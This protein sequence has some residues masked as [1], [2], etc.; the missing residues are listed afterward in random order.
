MI[1]ES[2]A[3]IASPESKGTSRMLVAIV[4]GLLALF[5]FISLLANGDDSETSTDPREHL[6]MWARFVAH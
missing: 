6:P 3:Q 2:P 4:I 5:S 1:V